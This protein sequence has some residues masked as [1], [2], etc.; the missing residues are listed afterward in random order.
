MLAYGIVYVPQRLS[1]NVTAYSASTKKNA[2][3]VEPVSVLKNISAR[4]GLLL[5]RNRF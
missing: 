1:S 5:R 3:D 2:P 4:C